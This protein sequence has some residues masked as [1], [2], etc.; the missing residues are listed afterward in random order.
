ML[1]RSS[2]AAGTPTAAY[3]STT[4]ATSSADAA[5]ERASR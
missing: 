3:F 1:E 4:A 2:T 5:R